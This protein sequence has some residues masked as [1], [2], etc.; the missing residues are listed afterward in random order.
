M[1]V[2][3]R[4]ST[5][6]PDAPMA[7]SPDSLPAG[8]VAIAHS[9]L[10]CMVSL[11]LGRRLPLD[12]SFCTGCGF[13]GKEPNYPTHKGI[14]FYKTPNDVPV[15]RSCG[16]QGTGVSGANVYP[17][18]P[19]CSHQATPNKAKVIFAGLGDLGPCTPGVDCIGN[20][21]ILEHMDNTH[22]VWFRTVYMHLESILV[23]VGQFVS[24]TD[25]IGTVG[26]SGGYKS[27]NAHLHFEVNE[28]RPANSAW[29]TA[30]ELAL[31]P[32]RIVASRSAID[33]EL[34]LPPVEGGE[35]LRIASPPPPAQSPP[36]P[37]VQLPTWRPYPYLPMPSYDG[38]LSTGAT[39][40]LYGEVEAEANIY[41]FLDAPDH[42]IYIVNTW[43]AED[44]AAVLLLHASTSYRSMIMTFY[45]FS[46]ADLE[47]CACGSIELSVSAGD[48]ITLG[49][50]LGT[51]TPGAG[52]RAMVQWTVMVKT[53]ASPY[54]WEE[55]E[56]FDLTD[57]APW[58]TYQDD[59][60]HPN[61]YMKGLPDGE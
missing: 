3:G 60:V 35:L 49:T 37:S 26:H 19:G 46:C 45:G 17:A 25:A 13:G 27:T 57:S 32:D 23:S 29:R 36:K 14:D 48:R 38:G 1:R 47:P 11:L 33:P 39:Q 52:D 43:E 40:A 59:M 20:C 7:E 54:F 16:F 51:I 9:S 31:M 41:P 53:A 15:R 28:Q 21:V 34:Y 18:F 24:T 8:A 2:P 4:D 42:T 44:W 50:K 58:D 56:P 10:W 30:A 22:N 61:Q 12:P 5:S 6:G 55:G